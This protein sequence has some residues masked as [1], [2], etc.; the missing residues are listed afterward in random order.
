MRE[1]SVSEDMQQASRRGDGLSAMRSLSSNTGSGLHASS[2][3][4]FDVTMCD[5]FLYC[6][7]NSKIFFY[8]TTLMLSDLKCGLLA[9]QYTFTY[10]IL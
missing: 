6:I 8:E 1:A 10:K 4:Y 2:P 7:K 9:P 3:I 5:I